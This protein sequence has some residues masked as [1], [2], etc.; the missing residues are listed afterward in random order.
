MP[1]YRVQLRGENFLLNLTGEPELLGFRVVHYV[2]AED[3]AEAQRTAVILTRQNRELHDRLQ[4]IPANP[5][6]LECETVTRAWWRRS[7]QDGQYRFWPMERSDASAAS[8]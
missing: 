4:N 1:L 5:S 7:R 2:R 8:A 6:R 3:E